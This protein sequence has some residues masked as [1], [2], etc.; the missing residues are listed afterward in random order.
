VKYIMDLKKEKYIKNVNELTYIKNNA[1]QF[2]NDTEVLR[3]LEN[4][5]EDSSQYIII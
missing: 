5:K 2:Q 1:L 3:W 4:N